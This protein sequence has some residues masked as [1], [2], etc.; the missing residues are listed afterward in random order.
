MKQHTPEIT[1]RTGQHYHFRDAM[2]RQQIA[3]PTTQTQAVILQPF[4]AK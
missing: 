3:Q 1:E 4:H 2:H